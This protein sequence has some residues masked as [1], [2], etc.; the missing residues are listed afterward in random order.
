M[1]KTIYQVGQ[2]N[3]YIKNLFEHDYALRNISVRGEVSNCKYHSTGHIY[4]TLKDE[5]G[6]LSA[7][8]FA[9]SRQTGLQF[10]MKEGDRVVATGS[11][12]VYE[13]GGV[14]QLYAKSIEP[15]GV[16]DL[17]LKFEETRRRLEEMGMFDSAYKQAIP[18]FVSRVGVVTASTGAA[19]RDIVN[20]THRRNPGVQVILYPATVQGPTAA[21]SIVRG[22]RTLDAMG[23]DVLIVGR[24][25]GSI[26]DLWA[27]NEEIVARA[28]FDCHT[29]V[30]SA[31]GHE[32]DTTI[33]DF[34]ADLRAP[35]PSAAAEL[36][37]YDLED[38][39][40]ELRVDRTRLNRLM[41]G[42]LHEKQ[43]RLEQL[44]RR[45]DGLRPRYRLDRRRQQLVNLEQEM[46][47]LIHDR[48]RSE[49]HALALMGARLEGASPLT[50]LDRGYGYIEKDGKAVRSVEDVTVG[51]RLNVQLK[52]GKL[53]TEVTWIE[54]K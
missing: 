50:R 49:R 22:I 44:F 14:Y 31:V 39:L 13:R 10:H 27:F 40:E 36:A 51:D 24:G 23:L 3:A 21:P 33:A 34:A 26:E 30:I 18:R 6:V 42:K 53:Q 45:L 47:N 7:V 19:I 48:L 28:I 5:T 17:Y 54:K 43:Y 37:V 1:T 38:F 20:I 15:D 35:T 46:K 12:M 9:G 32:T 11:I 8:M 4:F 2:V 41:L 29:P 16:G 25:G 52:D